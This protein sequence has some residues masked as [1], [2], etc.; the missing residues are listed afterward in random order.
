[1]EKRERDKLVLQYLTETGYHL[2]AAAMREETGMASTATIDLPSGSLRELLD[3]KAERDAVEKARDT[4]E[5]DEDDDLRPALAGE[6][7]TFFEGELVLSLDLTDYHAT[8]GLSAR[9]LPS[10]EVVAGSVDR[11]L[12]ILKVLDEHGGCLEADTVGSP[13]PFPHV[14]SGPVLSIDYSPSRPEYILAGDMSGNATVF[15]LKSNDIVFTCE[16]HSKYVVRARWSVRYPLFAHLVRIS[17]IA[18]HRR[19]EIT[20]PLHPTT[21]VLN[22]MDLV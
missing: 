1:M 8:N 18:S 19:V 13:T 21:A 14:C 15:S 12:K 17:Q 10:G 5:I 11:K 6:E 16:K 3:Q 20:L 22:Y 2:A 9:L 4:S 7:P